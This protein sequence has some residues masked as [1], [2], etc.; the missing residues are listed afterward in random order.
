MMLGHN[1]REGTAKVSGYVTFG[2]FGLDREPEHLSA[3]LTGPV[4]GLMN[5][6]S[7]NALKHLKYIGRTDLGDGAIADVREHQRFERP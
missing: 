6:P 4:G 7:L 5:A 3:A 2:S 1:R